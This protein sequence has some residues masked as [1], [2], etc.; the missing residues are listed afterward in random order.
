MQIITRIEEMG[1]RSALIN[2]TLQRRRYFR[3]IIRLPMQR[4]FYFRFRWH[5]TPRRIFAF[6]QNENPSK[7]TILS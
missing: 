3:I 7:H 6:F 2:W 4:Q 1:E 5:P